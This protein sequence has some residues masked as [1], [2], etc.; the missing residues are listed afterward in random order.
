MTQSRGP[1]YADRPA[2]ATAGPSGRAPLGRRSRDSG[3]FCV[4]RQFAVHHVLTRG[5]SSPSARPN[6]HLP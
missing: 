6:P 3:C 4:L 2:A 5:F 1:V